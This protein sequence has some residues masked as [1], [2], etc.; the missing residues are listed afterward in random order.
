M[1]EKIYK[2]T[3]SPTAKTSLINIVK[4]I[5]E[6]SPQAAENVRKT[7]LQK[8][9]SLAKNP[10]KYPLESALSEIHGEFRFAKEWNYKIIFEIYKNKV[11]VLVIIHSK[12]DLPSIIQDII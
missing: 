8:I 1:V 3:I 4:Y 6:F 11:D 5:R 12:K 7:I 9:K 10:Q 2:V